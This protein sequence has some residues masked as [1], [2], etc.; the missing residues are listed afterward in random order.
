MKKYE[1][2][3]TYT[4]KPGDKQRYDIPQGKFTPEP[5]FKKNSPFPIRTYNMEVDAD[6]VKKTKTMFDKNMGT[7]LIELE[8]ASTVPSSL[9]TLNTG[10]N[11]LYSD[12]NSDVMDRMKTWL[13]NINPEI[14]ISQ[15]LLGTG[16]KPTKP[17]ITNP[18]ATNP[19]TTNPATTTTKQVPA[20]TEGFQ[21][22]EQKIAKMPV[23]QQELLEIQTLLFNNIIRNNGEKYNTYINVADIPK[24]APIDVLDHM[25]TGN[26]P[27]IH[28]IEN[29]AECLALGG[30]YVKIKNPTTLVKLELLPES[31]RVIDNTDQDELYYNKYPAEEI[32]RPVPK[33]IENVNKEARAKPAAKKNTKSSI[34]T[35]EMF[36]DF[37]ETYISRDPLIEMM[38]N[39]ADLTGDKA[40]IYEVATGFKNNGNNFPKPG[41]N[42]ANNTTSGLAQMEHPPVMNRGETFGNIIITNPGSENKL[43]KTL[44]DNWQLVL[45][46]VLLIIILVFIVK[47]WFRKN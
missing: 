5:T 9:T 29:K 34:K 22:E 46:A 23:Q 14:T 43:A 10:D 17:S 38:V 25:C 13:H 27:A 40:E 42:L 33:L 47:I 3:E 7:Y 15:T 6:N 30:K 32:E 36:T 18:A 41:Q 20:A 4:V 16:N 35:N 2:E 31:D 39:P 28:G 1:P 26:S 44:R 37:S 8:N 19:T 24:G 21:V 11:L 45:S 12:I